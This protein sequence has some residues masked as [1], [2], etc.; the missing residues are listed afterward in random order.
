MLSSQ[1]IVSTLGDGTNLQILRSWFDGVDLYEIDT[2]ILPIHYQ[3]HLQLCIVESD[4]RT[5]LFIDPYT[6]QNGRA[7]E[8]RFR[9]GILRSLAML[10]TNYDKE[11]EIRRQWRMESGSTLACS[12]NL[13]ERPLFDTISCGVLIC[14]YI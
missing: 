7:P 6:A 9:S 10:S 14:F 4:S 3:S 5:A 1:Y 12:L 8:E 13:P 2:I 11:H